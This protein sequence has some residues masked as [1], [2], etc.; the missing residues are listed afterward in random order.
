M[1]PL[2]W[3]ELLEVAVDCQAYRI[4]VASLES[5]WFILQATTGTYHGH[6]HTQLGQFKVAETEQM[7]CNRMWWGWGMNKERIQDASTTNKMNALN[8]VQG[9]I[10]YQGAAPYP[11]LRHPLITQQPT[12]LAS[13]R[14]ASQ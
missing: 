9:F 7:L 1:I 4:H 14:L 2:E 8:T 13:Q 11:V 3:Y 6:E 12:I 5:V 10:Q